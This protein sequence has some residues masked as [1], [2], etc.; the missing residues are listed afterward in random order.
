MKTLMASSCNIVLTGQF[1]R[2]L[3]LS[4]QWNVENKALDGARLSSVL[5]FLFLHIPVQGMSPPFPK[6]KSRIM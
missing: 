4:L 1:L 2:S 5:G 6:G 3:L